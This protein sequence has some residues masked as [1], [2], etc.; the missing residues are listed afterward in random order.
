MKDTN[1]FL[2]PKLHFPASILLFI[3]LFV[4]K[5]IIVFVCPRSLCW[6]CFSVISACR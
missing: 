3:F 1:S 5:G 4:L 2:S 6:N